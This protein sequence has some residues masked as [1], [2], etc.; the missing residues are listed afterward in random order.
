VPRIGT[1]PGCGTDHRA[2]I[3]VYVDNTEP[4]SDHVLTLWGWTLLRLHYAM[5]AR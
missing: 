2:R 4:H 5:R 3:H 1:A